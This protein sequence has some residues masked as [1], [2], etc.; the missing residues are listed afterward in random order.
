MKHK[1]LARFS[2]LLLTFAVG[3]GVAACSSGDE[4]AKRPE[5][6]TDYVT[7]QIL[8]DST[9]LVHAPSGVVDSSYR[10]GPSMMFEGDT[11]YVDVFSRAL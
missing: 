5:E 3:V 10:Y 2:C 4:G 11:L 8:P 9:K 7:L 1:F 6:F